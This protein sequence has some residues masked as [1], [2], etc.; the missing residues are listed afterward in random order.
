MLTLNPFIFGCHITSSIFPKKL[1]FTFILFVNT[2]KFYSFFLLLFTLFDN[3]NKRTMIET[4]KKNKFDVDNWVQFDFWIKPKTKTEVK[5]KI[6]IVKFR[7]GYKIDKIKR[8]KYYKLNQIRNIAKIYCNPGVPYYRDASVTKLNPAS[9][10][11]N[12]EILCTISRV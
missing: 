11:E 7:F 9:K 12:I 1:Y 8:I 2:A 4:R 5:S 10:V 3:M 6:T